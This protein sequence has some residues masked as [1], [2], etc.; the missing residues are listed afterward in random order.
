MEIKL[1]SPEQ[2]INQRNQQRNFKR[3]RNQKRNFKIK[4]LNL[5]FKIFICLETNENGNTCNKIIG[6]SK[7]SSK[8]E[9]YNDK[10]TH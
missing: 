10:C 3:R 5:N 9:V 6:Y 7:R 2:P 4:I 1:Q 8:R